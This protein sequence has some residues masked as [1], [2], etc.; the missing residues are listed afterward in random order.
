[1]K[2]VRTTTGF[3]FEDTDATDA[4]GL[5]IYGDDIRVDRWKDKK[6][7]ITIMQGRRVLDFDTLDLGERGNRNT[8]ANS[9]YKQIDPPPSWPSN[10]LIQLLVN[11]CD[12]LYAQHQKLAI[13]GETFGDEE[14]SRPNM[15]IDGLVVEGGGHLLFAPPGAGK[16]W[17]AYLMAQSVSYGIRQAFP[18]RKSMSVL[19]VNLERPEQSVK[20]R[21]GQVNQSLG[22]PRPT[23]AHMIHNRGATLN[24]TIDAIRESVAANEH[25]MVILDSLSRSGA[26]LVDDSDANRTM[27]AMNSLGVTWLALAHS[28]YGDNSKTF[29]SRMFQAAADVEIR[30]DSQ[31]LSRYQKAIRLRAVKANDIAPQTL[32]VGQEFHMDYGLAKVWQADEGEFPAHGCNAY[33]A[34]G[35]L[36]TRTTWGG[37]DFER[38]TYCARHRLERKDDD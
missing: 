4:T 7:K 6:A 21:L 20:R 33:D 29:G 35:N 3:M 18:V 37:V 25:G 15:V 2:Y 28:P 38:G 36:C 19:T 32:Y 34:K 11:F 14:P 1:M 10:V 12:G 23:P 9:A 22:I 13:A 8:L 5:T 26:S 30:L 16:S 17:V 27:D 31:S 24:D